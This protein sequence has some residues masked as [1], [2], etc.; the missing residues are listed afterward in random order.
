MEKAKQRL[1]ELQIHTYSGSKS[2]AGDIDAKLQAE[3]Q[4]DVD[5]VAKMQTE[6]DT[7]TDIA[8]DAKVQIGS[9]TCNDSDVD[10]TLP[11]AGDMLSADATKTG[12][13]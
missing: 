5:V 11:V 9:D 12:S 10:M 7:E 2:A 13:T 8:E 4:S 1:A 3:S 6:S